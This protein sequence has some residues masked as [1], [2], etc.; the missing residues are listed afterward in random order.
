MEVTIFD[1]LQAKLGNFPLIRPHGAF[2]V[3]ILP[4]TC[5]LFIMPWLRKNGMFTAYI[6]ICSYFQA[7]LS[8]VYSTESTSGYK[9]VVLAVA[10]LPPS[11]SSLQV[12]PPQWDFTCGSQ[13]I[14]CYIQDQKLCAT[15]TACHHNWWHLVDD[16]RLDGLRWIYVWTFSNL[17]TH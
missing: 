3:P 5:N 16:V 1:K 6:V 2:L 13:F 10:S 9:I 8:L 4:V 15:W 7:E 11:V 14:W 12:M 17:W